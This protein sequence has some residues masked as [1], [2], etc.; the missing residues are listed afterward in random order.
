ME[1]LSIRALVRLSIE[2]IETKIA[3]KRSA[4]HIRRGIYC[5]LLLWLA[6][7]MTQCSSPAPH[8]PSR[9][10]QRWGVAATHDNVTLL[11]AI[12]GSSEYPAWS[13]DGTQ[14]AFQHTDF[15]SG[16]E[17]IAAPRDIY[18]MNADGT[19]ERRLT[20][21][22]EKGI[23]CEHPSWAPDSR[24]MV[25]TC[26]IEKESDL[27]IL[28]AT[29]GAL[30]Q[31]TDYDGDEITPTWSPD[32][33]R[34][35]FA[36]NMST[37]EG[38]NIYTVNSD[39]TNLTRLTTGTWDI[40]PTW[41]PDSQRIGFSAGETY[42]SAA[43]CFTDTNGSTLACVD[44]VQCRDDAWSPEGSQIACISKSQIIAAGFES[45]ESLTLLETDKYV[46][47]LS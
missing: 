21:G 20:Q 9:R 45:Q 15:R 36:S 35:A 40:D 1:M 24:R 37:A 7:E 42:S 19:G 46:H 2:Q 18:V 27:Y 4:K 39:G 32:G 22:A 23:S 47:G 38:Y 29:S 44:N 28:D 30:T 11:S 31:L 3:M 41:S 12:G 13:P 43:L 33:V 25:C 26:T 5:V 34:I 6:I 17:D 8:A 16:S 14:I 10:V